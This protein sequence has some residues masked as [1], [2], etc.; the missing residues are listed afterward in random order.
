MFR[1]KRKQVRNSQRDAELDLEAAEMAWSNFKTFY[2]HFRDH[3]SMG[4]GAVED[5]AVAPGPSVTREEGATNT[6][7]S[8]RCPSQLASGSVRSGSDIEEEEDEE[9]TVPRPPKKKQTVTEMLLARNGRKKGKLQYL[10]A[11]EDHTR[12]GP[13]RDNGT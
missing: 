10:V 13:A 7:D 6:P 2:M 4:L 8:S 12:R 1:N 9:L 3:P 11:C 5:S